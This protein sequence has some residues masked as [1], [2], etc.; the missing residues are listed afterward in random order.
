MIRMVEMSVRLGIKSRGGQIGHKKRARLP[1]VPVGRERVIAARGGSLDQFPQPRYPLKCPSTG[2]F[3]QFE[4]FLSPAR[5]AGLP[6][7]SSQ[8]ERRL[9]ARPGFE[10]G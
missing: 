5:G 2:N 7:C 4:P 6:S 8:S 10:P 1:R 9:E 3:E